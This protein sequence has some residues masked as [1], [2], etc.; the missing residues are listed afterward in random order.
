VERTW[1]Y[2][3]HWPPI[4]QAGPPPPSPVFQSVLE[5][6]LGGHPVGSAVEYVNEFYS[7]IAVVLNDELQHIEAG[8]DYEPGELI[9]LWSANNDARGYIVIGD[10]AVQLPLAP[11][12]PAETGDEPA[13]DAAAP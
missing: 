2:S 4:E 11:A 5:H 7:E 3:F 1:P 8:G 10:P 9:D 6:L 13:A 12:P